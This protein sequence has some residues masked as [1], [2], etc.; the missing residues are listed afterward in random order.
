MNTVT[1][2]FTVPDADA[3]AGKPQ[4][5]KELI[6]DEM[7]RLLGSLERERDSLKVKY[8]PVSEADRHGN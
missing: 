1:V 7:L 3:R 2:T 8:A 6:F 5:L 4:L